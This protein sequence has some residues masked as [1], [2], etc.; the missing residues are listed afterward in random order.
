MGTRFL[1]T[2][3]GLADYYTM[4]AYEDKSSGQPLSKIS[5]S[6]GR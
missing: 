1:T 5:E 4:A 3:F 6:G 2:T